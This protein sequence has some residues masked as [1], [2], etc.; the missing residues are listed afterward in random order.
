MSKFIRGAVTT[1]VFVT[2]GHAVD[3]L[4][5]GVAVSLLTLVF[6]LVEPAPAP[7]SAGGSQRIDD[8]EKRG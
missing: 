7:R 8:E 2:V 3:L 6:L 5:V 4:I 1:A